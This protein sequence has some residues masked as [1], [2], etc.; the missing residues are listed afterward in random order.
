MKKI[1]I[2]LLVITTIDVFGIWGVTGHR[3]VG[4]IAENHLTSKTRK[5]LIEIL[6]GNITIENTGFG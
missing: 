3:T 1:L 5:K 4:N 6:D 2:V